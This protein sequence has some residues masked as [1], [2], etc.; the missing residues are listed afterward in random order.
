MDVNSKLRAQLDELN[1]A[2]N[3]DEETLNKIS[4]QVSQGF[5]ADILS[6]ADW[7]RNVNEWTKLALQTKEEKKKGE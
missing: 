5:E 6:R 4:E 1:I 2:D 7:E 3:L